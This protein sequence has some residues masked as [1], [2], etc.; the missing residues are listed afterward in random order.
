MMALAIGF[1]TGDLRAAEPEVIPLWKNGA[2]GFESRRDEPELARDYWVRNINN[3]TLT[4]YL[5]P[6]D[7][8]NGAAVLIFPG[9][10]FRELVV[11][12]EGEEPA[13]FLN[14]LGVAAFVLKYRLP[15]ETNSPY[16][17]EI[18]PRQ[19]AQ[20]AMRLIRTRAAEWNLDRKRIGILGFSAGGEVAAWL[21]YSPPAGDPAAADPIDRT[22]CGVNF[23]M[24][25]Y[26]G[27]LGIPD[28]IPADAP[29]AFFVVANDDNSHV[30]P[31]LKQMEAYR[32]AHRPVE[33]HLYEA[34]GHG[35]NMGNRS[36]L[37]SI[38]GWPQRMTDWMADNHLLGS[39]TKAPREAGAEVRRP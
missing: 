3:P 9:G 13:R 17:L 19:D 24:V 8:A 14:R 11:K 31:V 5:P 25:I 20:R 16:S 26:P 32:K 10:G 37:E 6:K 39:G 1:A 18:H 15:R 28:Q 21:A 23:Q 36:K 12:A 7:Q 29:P 33:V 35:F 34:G 2:P 4:V 30:G 27:P 22:D 38:R